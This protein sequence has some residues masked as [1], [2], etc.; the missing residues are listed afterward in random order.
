MDLYGGVRF[1]SPPT[2]YLIPKFKDVKIQEA[3][4]LSCVYLN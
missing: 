1:N 3:K 4:E 2:L